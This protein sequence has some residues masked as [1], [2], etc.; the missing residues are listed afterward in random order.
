MAF[1]KWQKY[2]EAENLEKMQEVYENMNEYINSKNDIKM[3]YKTIKSVENCFRKYIFHRFYYCQKSPIDYFFYL[4][5]I[6]YIEKYGY[7]RLN[8]NF[9][10]KYLN[11]YKG[12][13]I[14]I[15]N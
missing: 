4:V 8:V 5:K 3:K 6:N 7:L 2:F 11:N 14:W 1:S 10:M 9:K 13:L 15:K 12:E